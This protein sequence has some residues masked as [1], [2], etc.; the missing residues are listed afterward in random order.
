M[1]TNIV[2]RRPSVIP[3]AAAGPALRYVLDF[4][5]LIWSGVREGVFVL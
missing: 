2:A 5:W 4:G 1:K 3:R